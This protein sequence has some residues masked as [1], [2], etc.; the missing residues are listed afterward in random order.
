MMTQYGPKREDIILQPVSGKALEVYRGEV[1]RII[2]I[3]GEQCVDFDAFNLHDYKEYLGVSNTRSKY[4][5]RPKKGDMIWSVHSRNRPM[6]IILEMPQTCVTDLLGGRC[7]AANHYAEGFTPTAYGAHTNCQ[8]TFAACIGEYGLTPDD[9]HDSFNM[10]MNTEWDSRGQYWIVRNTGRKGDYVDLLAMFDILA[11]PI[12]CGSGDT[13][14][15]SNYGF[16]PIQV[17]V[18]RP[19]AETEAICAS[20]AS[21]YESVQRRLE[22]F[23]VKEIHSERELKRKPNYRA[24]FVNFPI[25]TKKIP[26]ELTEEQ[27]RAL[28]GLK[29]HGLGHTDG[30]ALRTAFFTW[31]HRN[32]RPVPLRGRVRQS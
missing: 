5:F 28:Q 1:L 7:Q 2:Q 21:K 31:Y 12:I 25:R 23:K 18:F 6:F 10:W 20:C 30:E 26:V 15:T 13:Q 19:S 9:V 24:E 29:E 11:V 14:I 22:H 17:Q 4:G 27:F 32:R 3:E 16:K 8:D